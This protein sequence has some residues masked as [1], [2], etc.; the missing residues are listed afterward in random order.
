MKKV[1][2]T[3]GLPASGKSTW[4]KAQMTKN[5]GR[6]KRVNRDSLRLMLDN[7]QFNPK[8]EK[9][10]TT[11]QRQLIV[12]ALDEGF[13]VIVDDTNLNPK[14]ISAFK[15]L[16]KGKA[17][18]EVKDF[19]DAPLERCIEWYLKR[20]ASVGK[21]VIVRM[22]KQY[23]KP[24]VQKAKH[25][26]E[27]PSAIICDLDGTLCNM[28]ARGPFEYMKCDTDLPNIPVVNVVEKYANDLQIIFLSGREDMAKEKTIEWINKYVPALNGVDWQLHMR[29][30][31]DYR[32][33]NIVKGELYEAHVKGKYNVLFVLDDRN[34]V[35]E[36]WRD[37]GLTCFQVNEGD[38]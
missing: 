27:L 36:L 29:K 33:D 14:Y 19:T 12:S 25:F 24:K 21:D 15:E 2:L 1:I 34:Q 37:L 6:Y 20:E 26:A 30:S 22:Y 8:R 3:V 11:A 9:F 7:E 4:A 23:L 17:E 38:F 35:V 5:P 18:V 28:V 31:G 16:V 13:H 32:K 10:I